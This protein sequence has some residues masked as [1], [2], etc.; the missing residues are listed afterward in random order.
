MSP[1]RS[2]SMCR[3]N[4]RPRGRLG[5]LAGLASPPGFNP[6]P[7]TMGDLRFRLSWRMN[8][9]FQSTPPH[10]GRPIP[11]TILNRIV[12][13]QPASPAAGAIASGPHAAGSPSGFNPR[14][15]ERRRLGDDHHDDR[16]ASARAA[17]RAGNAA[18]CCGQSRVPRFNSRPLARGRHG[19][20]WP[21]SGSGSFNP[22]PRTGGD[23]RNADP[24]SAGTCSNPRPAPGVT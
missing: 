18:G 11:T 12:E 9:M 17:V 1:G 3:F 13:F 15:H 8:S 5:R 22:R 23:S 4:S 14:V 19:R 6:R 24:E 2:C 7:H 16:N 20:R 10:E 21:P